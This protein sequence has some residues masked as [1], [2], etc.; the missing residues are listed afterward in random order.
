MSVILDK[1]EQPV[2]LQM[3]RELLE[4]DYYQHLRMPQGDLITISIQTARQSDAGSD[5]PA[6]KDGLYA[7]LGKIKVVPLE[8]RVDDCADVRIT[9]DERAWLDMTEPQQRALLDEL[10]WSLEKQ[11]DDVG[12]I[13]LD[14]HNRPKL[15]VRACDW[16]ISGFRGVAE[17]HGE[18]AP[19]V[20]A[21]RRFQE[22]HGD[23]A[24][25][26]EDPSLFANA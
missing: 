16:R 12:A 10:L 5:E 19:C 18:N 24:L 23:C 13:K 4:Q 20:V 11:V 8:Q 25:K 22:R 26:K 7:V 14:D 17:R 1:K 9:L 6:L 15:K 21:A 3:C 2:A